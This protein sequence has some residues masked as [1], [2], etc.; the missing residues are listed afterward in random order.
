MEQKGKLVVISGFSGA[1]KGSLMKAVLAAHPDLDIY[2]GG[3]DESLN[4]NGYIVPGQG[5]A[6]ERIIGTK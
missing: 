6:G 3:M 1:G 4:E 2:C 5:E